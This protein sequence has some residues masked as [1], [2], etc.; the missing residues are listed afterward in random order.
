MVNMHEIH[1]VI[2]IVTNDPIPNPVAV[3]FTDF[4]AA[5]D[6]A[7]FSLLRSLPSGSS[8]PS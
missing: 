4:S 7:A 3:V 8:L 6:G 1:A 2:I 5:L